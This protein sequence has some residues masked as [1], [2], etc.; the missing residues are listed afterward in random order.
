METY[1]FYSIFKN[2]EYMNPM[3]PDEVFTCTDL[4]NGKLSHTDVTR[5]VDYHICKQEKRMKTSK[6]STNCLNYRYLGKLVD[7]L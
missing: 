6:T 1:I 7:T 4:Q 3:N 5:V 2:K